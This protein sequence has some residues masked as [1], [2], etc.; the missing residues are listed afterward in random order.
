M[1]LPNASRRR[2]P[3]VQRVI[4]LGLLLCMVLLSGLA[5]QP[6]AAAPPAAQPAAKPAAQPP[7]PKEPV[8]KPEA[9]PVV[10]GDVRPDGSNVVVSLAWDPAAALPE[11]ARLVIRAQDGGQAGEEAWIAPDASGAFVE[12]TVPAALER[13]HEQGLHYLITVEDA[14]GAALAEY[15]YLVMLT[16]E[17]ERTCA[18]KLIGGVR[19][20]GALFVSSEL[21]AALDELGAERPDDV[22]GAILERHP[23]LRGDVYTLAMQ[24]ER[25]QPAAGAQQPNCLCWW[26]YVVSFTPAT[27]AFFTGFAPPAATKAGFNGTGAA[28]YFAAKSTNGAIVH[29]ISGDTTI[30]VKMRCWGITGWHTITIT[31]HILWWTIHIHINV[32]VFGYCQSQCVGKVTHNAHYQA[33]INADAYGPPGSSFARASESVLYKVDGNTVFSTGSTVSAS[34]PTTNAANTLAQSGSWSSIEP[35][36]AKLQTW[37]GVHVQAKQGSYAYARTVNAYQMKATATA[38]CTIPN[39][40]TVYAPYMGSPLIPSPASNLYL[41]LDN[42]NFLNLYL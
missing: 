41:W 35:S 17:D 15:P 2:L 28:H 22:L 5:S 9:S 4:A 6:A 42:V 13:V 36:T 18:Y 34:P 11:Q 33:R 1:G 25:M 8:A 14:K 23:E 16:C 26:T 27:N 37:G 39:T 7:A 12:A 32:P 10:I 40:V 38:P 20:D 30:T 24:L 31:I 21:D 29:T 3:F 19:T